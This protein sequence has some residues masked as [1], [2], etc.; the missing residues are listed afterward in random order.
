MPLYPY[1]NITT[2]PIKMD[3]F[4][5]FILANA[6]GCHFPPNAGMSIES[7]SDIIY[8]IKESVE[9][10]LEAIECDTCH[11]LLCT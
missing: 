8:N 1:A 9:Q 4:K 7:E 2:N 3:C 5:S 6:V 11:N 10:K